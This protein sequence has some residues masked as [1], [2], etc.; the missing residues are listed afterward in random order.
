MAD[1]GTVEIRAEMAAERERLDEARTA[2]RAELRSLVP[3]AVAGL[4]I[5]GIVTARMGVR[6]GLA[7]VRKLS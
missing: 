2:L 5:V 1:R 3:F 6:A 4:A 7:T